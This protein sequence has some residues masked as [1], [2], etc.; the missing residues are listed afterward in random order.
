[1]SAPP[2]KLFFYQRQQQTKTSFVRTGWP[3]LSWISAQLAIAYLWAVLG[4]LH[5]VVHS[6]GPLFQI[7]GYINCNKKWVG[8]HVGKCFHKLIRSHFLRPT[9]QRH[10]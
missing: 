4:R 6:I 3:D 1:L 10:W 9:L 7:E 5:S 2:F 8:Q